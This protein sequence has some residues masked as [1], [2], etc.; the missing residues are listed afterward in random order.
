MKIDPSNPED[1]PLASWL[2]VCCGDEKLDLCELA[3]EEQGLAVVV[4]RGPDG[5]I[6][7]RGDGP[8]RTTM[9]GRVRLALKEGAPVSV[10]AEYEAR[11]L[12]E[13]VKLLP[14]DKAHTLVVVV[15]PRTDQLVIARLAAYL[16]VH[17]QD[18]P[19]IVVAADRVTSIP[20]DHIPVLTFDAVMLPEIEAIRKAWKARWG[21]ERPALMVVS[22][23]AS[24]DTLPTPS[25]AELFEDMKIARA[26]PCIQD[27]I[28]LLR[29]KY[30]FVKHAGPT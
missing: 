15:E 25:D 28:V 20:P 10:R 21:T 11:R 3:D 9:R 6:V 23:P 4:E 18:Q 12:S 2:D 17:L 26:A 19:A 7:C 27:A 16:N 13:R 24:I 14:R 29:R 5:K 1:R 22:P 8:A 30:A